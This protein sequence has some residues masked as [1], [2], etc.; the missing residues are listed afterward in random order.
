M[1]QVVTVR[2]SVIIAPLM[3]SRLHVLPPARTSRPDFNLRTFRRSASRP[4]ELPAI[5]PGACGTV[6]SNHLHVPAGS[7]RVAPGVYETAPC[8]CIV[9]VPGPQLDDR[10]IINPSGGDSSMPIVR[11]DLRFIPRGQQQK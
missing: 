5:P 1:R 4:S 7:P 3:M 2:N 6:R 10:C 11:P 8:S 9:V